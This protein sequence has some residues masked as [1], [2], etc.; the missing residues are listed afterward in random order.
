MS[1]RSDT[2]H[3]VDAAVT[4]SRNTA[5]EQPVRTV[6]D[7]LDGLELNEE[8]TNR[9]AYELEA[10]RYLKD[11]LWFLAQSVNRVEQELRERVDRKKEATTLSY[12]KNPDLDGIPYG[13][14]AS[15]FHWYATSACNMVRLVG[16]IGRNVD[17]G[18][19]SPRRYMETVLPRITAF[20][21]K[22]AA[23]FSGTLDHNHDT[24]AERML[25]MLPPVVFTKGYF[26]ATPFV[27]VRAEADTLDSSD[28]SA[29]K[30][31]SLTVAHAEL[32][33]RYWNPGAPHVGAT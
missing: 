12:S 2:G 16:W 21:D 28:T 17:D 29:M 4:E 3:K 1:N 24:P 19:P 7:H 27:L 14:I 30:P 18:R 11:G 15:S 10:I 22:I 6:L 8:A 33:R 20:R 5:T 23:H 13:V 26:V 9:F 31:W 32:G 25:S